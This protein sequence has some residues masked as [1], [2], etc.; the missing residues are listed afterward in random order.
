MRTIPLFSFL[1]SIAITTSCVGT[2]E[3]T[4]GVSAPLAG[5]CR[6]CVDWLNEPMIIAAGELCVGSAWR[7][8]ALIDCIGTLGD[9]SGVLRDGDLNQEP[10]CWAAV[11]DQCLGQYASCLDP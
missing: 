5:G 4:A 3:E 11:M 10:E 1:L 9:C 8:E 6:T 7:A 2:P